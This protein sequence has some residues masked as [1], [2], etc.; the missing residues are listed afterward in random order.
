[1]PYQKII[2]PPGVNRDATQYLL[3]DYGWYDT[4]NVRFRAG[5][6]EK[7]GGWRKH[8]TD[9]LE[10]VP[11][12]MH[13]WRDLN[14][15]VITGIATGTHVYILRLGVLTDITPVDATF[16]PDVDT[17][18]SFDNWG[19]DLVM[20]P[21]GGPVYLWG[22]DSPAGEA[23]K[24]ITAPSKVQFLLVTDDRH[25]ACFGC[26]YDPISAVYAPPGID[27]NK[28]DTLR[29]Q[30]SGQ[31]DLTF[32]D[33][34]DEFKTAGDFRFT[35]GSALISAAKIDTIIMVW[36]EESAHLMQLVDPPFVFRFD[37]IGTS[38]GIISPRAWA[39]HNGVL[40]W[41][42]DAAF[43]KYAGGVTPVECPLEDYLFSRLNYSQRR[44]VFAAVDRRNDEFL[45]F[46]PMQGTADT[47]VLHTVDIGAV[48][49]DVVSTASFDPAG[50]IDVGGVGYN[51]T[52]VTESSFTGVTKEVGGAIDAVIA[53]GTAVS[54]E[55]LTNEETSRY[56]AF[57]MK[58]SAWWLGRM[59]RTAWADRGMIEHPIAAR[60]DGQLFEQDYGTDADGAPMVSY[61][62][63]CEF[64]LESGDE[65]MFVRRFV[66]DFAMQGTLRIALRTRYFPHSEAAYEFIGDVTPSTEF[67]DTRIR[68]RQASFTVSSDGLGDEWRLGACRLDVQ[69][70]GRKE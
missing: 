39:V 61:L 56:V 7:I 68:G 50:E 24:V 23:K 27:A 34:G 4:H 47:T 52:G 42:G 60:S 28:L 35:G 15:V 45:W 64:D 57:G 37:Q 54:G 5:M 46:Y 19:Q 16:T 1:M 17:L 38:T 49:I 12:T 11:R 9:V 48:D 22:A 29:V 44:R 6:P 70:D 18:W 66:P 26:N 58:E 43:Y 40:M 10:G 59:D 51:Y 62:E 21:W 67:I 13:V 25:L 55:I 69:P 8:I 63:S 53:V 41:M 14:G 33:I 32:W 30:W 2:I 3:E 31:E 36:T 65:L 20:C